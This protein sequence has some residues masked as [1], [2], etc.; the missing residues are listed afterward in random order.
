MS[1]LYK[2]AVE[3]PLRLAGVKPAANH[4]DLAD[5]GLTRSATRWAVNRQRQFHPFRGTYLDGAGQPDLLDRL[6]ALFL[7]LPKNSAVG[8]HTA[9]SLYGFGV[10]PA[11]QSAHSPSAWS[12]DTADPRSRR[13][14]GS[15]ALRARH[16]TGPAMRSASEVRH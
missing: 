13:T 7:I 3:L 11:G 8:F 15:P 4:H 16:R 5:S 1:D 14:R 10:L 9:A 12:A 6:H 2:E